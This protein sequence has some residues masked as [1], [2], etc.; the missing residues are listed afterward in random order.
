M[1]LSHW[2]D[3]QDRLLP[4]IGC[5]A[6]DTLDG[7]AVL[8][9][10]S[11]S[12]PGWLDLNP[13]FR[14][15]QRFLDPGD[16]TLNGI[17]PVLFLC[18]VASGFDDQYTLLGNTAACQLDQALFD[19]WIQGGG[20]A[21]I[22]PELNGRRNLIYILAARTGCADKIKLDLTFINFYRRSNLNHPLSITVTL[23]GSPG[24]DTLGCEIPMKVF[25]QPLPG[26]GERKPKFQD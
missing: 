7:A 1:V 19:I 17:Q 11:T 23:K 10:S 20:I 3:K 18:A 22:K 21:N 8:L 6:P 12:G 13:R 4:F 25:Y 15:F 2:T 9:I 24:E 14:H 5:E 16:Q 26:F